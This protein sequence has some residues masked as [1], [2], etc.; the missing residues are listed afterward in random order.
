MRLHTINKKLKQLI[1]YF[2]QAFISL[3]DG[4]NIIIHIIIMDENVTYISYF[5]AYICYSTR[6]ISKK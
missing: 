6:I 3:I 5:V 1:T 4:N 2:L